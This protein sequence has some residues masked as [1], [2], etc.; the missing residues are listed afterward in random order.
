MYTVPQST[1]VIITFLFF[2]RYSLAKTIKTYWKGFELWEV[3]LILILAQ[4]FHRHR[5]VSF[6]DD[7][8]SIKAT[9]G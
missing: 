4:N 3:Y 1:Y 5:L 8:W 6:N 2:V 9:H 7:H